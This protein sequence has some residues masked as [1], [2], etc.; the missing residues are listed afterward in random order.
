MALPVA[1]LRSLA[2]TWA[3]RLIFS[4]NENLFPINPEPFYI[5]HAEAERWTDAGTEFPGTALLNL[6]LP[7]GMIMPVDFPNGPHFVIAGSTDP[8]GNNL[9]AT[10][11][12]VHEHDVTANRDLFLDFAGWALEDGAASPDF[13]IGNA[14]ILRESFTVLKRAVTGDSRIPPDLNLRFDLPVFAPPNMPSVF[15]EI[16]WAGRYPRVDLSNFGGLS[17]LVRA[18]DKYLCLTYYFF[19]PLTDQRAVPGTGSNV[20]LQREGQWEA[21]S[22]YLKGTQAPDL[23]RQDSTGQPI[24]DFPEGSFWTPRFLAYS[25][26]QHSDEASPE[27]SVRPVLSTDLSTSGL[28]TPAYGN[29]E[30]SGPAPFTMARAVAPVA[31]P[32]VFVAQGTHQCMFEWQATT[33][34][35]DTGPD[36]AESAAGAALTGIGSILTLACAGA[37]GTGVLAPVAG[38]LCGLG[39]V[40]FLLGG[41]LSAVANANHGHSTLFSPDPEGDF[42]PPDGP[43]SDPTGVILASPAAG[44]VTPYALNVLTNLPPSPGEEGDPIFTAPAWWPYDGRWGVMVVPRVSSG[45]D[46]GMRRVDSMGRTKAYWNTLE[47]IRFVNLTPGIMP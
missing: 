17:D 1:T 43:I 20:T 4:P 42:V 37:A 28:Q 34:I 41:I 9:S 12:A 11:L 39:I 40:A 16:E 10:D 6:D 45:W 21:I 22:V 7:L 36:P 29:G 24:P 38:V 27:A 18:L 3:P 5:G 15:C 13:T 26:T 2:N 23:S 14:R 8:S 31:N 19:Y 33:T 30:F 44:M 35:I 25:R 47:T 46:S 32:I